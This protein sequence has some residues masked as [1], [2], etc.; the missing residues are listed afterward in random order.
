MAANG[1]T[2]RLPTWDDVS[3]NARLALERGALQAVSI[4]TR[5]TA[6]GIGSDGTAFK[7]YTPAYARRKAATGRNVVPPDLTLTGTMLR[8]LRVLRVEPSGKRAWIGWEGQHTTRNVFAL[9]PYSAP[10]AARL[11]GESFPLRPEANDVINRVNALKRREARRRGR[12]ITSIAYA[13]LIP[14][15]DSRRPFF[16]LD[17]AAERNQVREVIQTTMTKRLSS[18]LNRPR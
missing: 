13:K 12:A 10:R 8:G 6:K 7:P 1:I 17:L 11:L 5:R 2:F 15:L 16:H 3:R 14:A 4:I 18:D 9:A